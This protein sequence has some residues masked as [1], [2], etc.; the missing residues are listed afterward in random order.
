MAPFPTQIFLVDDHPIIRAGFRQLLDSEDEF[1]ICGEAD[2]GEEALKKIP[3]TEADLALVDIS[4][5]G[6]DGIELTRRLK[7]SY[8]DLKVLIVSMHNEAR[9]VEDALEAGASGYVLKD[10]VHSEL[11]KAACEVL[12]GKTYLCDA[13]KDLQVQPLQSNGK[14][15]SNHVFR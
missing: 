12:D 10:H 7:E 5:N 14:T 8:P 11:Q 6:M 1:V 9:Y 13:L 4:M 3:D 2:S 15:G